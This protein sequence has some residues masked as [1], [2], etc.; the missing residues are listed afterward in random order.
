[1]DIKDSDTFEDRSAKRLKTDPRIQESKETTIT[2]A[3]LPGETAD[4]EAGKEESEVRDT[5]PETSDAHRKPLQEITPPSGTPP[6]EEVKL[7]PSLDLQPSLS[8]DSPI[9]ASTDAQALGGDGR[10]EMTTVG[11]DN[12]DDE[13]VKDAMSPQ[14]LD[15][16]AADELSEMDAA[17]DGKEEEVPMEEEGAKADAEFGSGT[18]FGSNAVWGANPSPFGEASAVARGP[19]SFGFSGRAESGTGSAAFLNIKPPGTSTEAPIF[20]FGAA[21]SITLPTPS[22]PNP[23]A[24]SPFGA[25]ASS[26][27][28]SFGG[29][30]S[31]APGSS[32]SALPLFGSPFAASTS[33]SGAQVLGAVEEGGE[34]MEDGEGDMDADT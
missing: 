3:T 31:P 21:S 14:P 2:D 18:P 11:N 25:F 9:R 10:N 6:S 15:E 33:A 30:G 7:E 32:M 13:T 1:L 28:A 20:S 8:V 16:E 12:M 27:V 24:T 5:P 17:A 26:A 23:A 34:E 29:F 4:V 22:L 19:S